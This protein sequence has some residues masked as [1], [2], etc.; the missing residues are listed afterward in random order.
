MSINFEF[1]KL[2]KITQDSLYNSIDSN[3]GIKN[4]QVYLPFFN[5]YIKFHNK[6]S[7]KM[8]NLK[9][10]YTIL[11]VNPVEETTKNKLQGKLNLKL[12]KNDFYTKAKDFND[13]K[14]Y[15]IE[16]E[17]FIKSNPLVDVLKFM[18]GD[19]EFNSLIPSNEGNLT[20]K[21]IN[22]PNN[23]AYMEIMGCYV[24][25]KL[26]LN[27][28]TNIFPEY[29]GSFNGIAESYE[30]DISEDYNF[31]NNDDWFN[32]RNGKEFDL[33]FDNN[34]DDYEKLSLENLERLD[35]KKEKKNNVDIEIYD[36]ELDED[37]IEID[38]E[39]IYKKKTSEANI[40]QI[41]D[42]ENS[43]E[44]S[45]DS[46]SDSE[47]NGSWSTFD[48]NDSVLAAEYW[49]K[50]KNIPIQILCMESMNQTLTELEEEGLDEK[51]WLSIIFQICFGLA[52]SQEHLGFI[53]NDLHS[54][55]IMFKNV[56]EEF[57]YFRYQ[58]LFFRVPTFGK[59]LKI[60]DF[61]RS[62][63]KIKNHIYYSDVFEKNG[64]AGGQ[65]G[66]P[67]TMFLKKKINYNFDLA[68]LSTTIIEFFDSESPIFDLLVDWTK[69]KEEG[70]EK[71]FNQLEDSFSLYIAITK[72]SRNALPKNQLPKEIFNLFRIQP[73]NIPKES[74]IYQF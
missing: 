31:I 24:A 22:N 70:I 59:E 8:F 62:I 66:N 54:D 11:E 69:Y 25:N 44:L 36:D 67:P 52:A 58:D 49:V 2:K 30:H 3:L 65:Y 10:K 15:I 29:F 71:N 9:G 18:E 14:N 57:K 32:E 35:Y 39:E 45:D 43:E 40:S 73:E 56:D 27:N 17:V 33:I 60:I 50:L 37:Q 64:D 72:Y 21:K 61:A 26:N 63:F 13:Y 74:L 5:K 16:R 38:L 48:S 41:S 4:S 53:H 34:L 55:N 12:I 23:N 51:Q 42:D 20:N 28:Y 68:R 1:H 47:S 46:N 7:K 19:Y 6:Y